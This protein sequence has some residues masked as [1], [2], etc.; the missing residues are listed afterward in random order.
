[1]HGCE[2]YTVLSD[3][4]RAQGNVLPN[5]LCDWNLETGWYRFQGAAGDRMLDKCVF[6]LMPRCVIYAPSWLND[7]HPTVTD[8]VVTRKVCY[9]GPRSC[10]D[11]D[12]IIKV[13]NCSSYYVYKLQKTRNGCYRYCGNAD[14]SKL[15]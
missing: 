8:G 5:Q 9:H 1:M 12:N 13:K 4:D 2:N 11:W 3:A 10:C 14:S 15:H 7:P 6:R